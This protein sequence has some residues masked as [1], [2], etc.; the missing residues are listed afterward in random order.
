MKDV[1]KIIMN[2]SY[3]F[4]GGLNALS[5]T[6]TNTPVM[7]REKYT[8]FSVQLSTTAKG[9]LLSGS[10]QTSPLCADKSNV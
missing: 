10:S 1:N 6:F 8:H 5:Q 7:K 4:K 3:Y 2:Q 9:A